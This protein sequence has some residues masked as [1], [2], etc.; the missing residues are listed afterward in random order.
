MIV[1]IRFIMYIY[2]YI[3]LYCSLNY[4]IHTYIYT[5]PV[6]DL[7]QSNWVAMP[8]LR[9]APMSMRKKE[10]YIYIWY[11]QH[12]KRATSNFVLIL[13]ICELGVPD[14]CSQNV[15]KQMISLLWGMVSIRRISGL[16]WGQWGIVSSLLV[17]QIK[18]ATV[19][20]RISHYQL[21]LPRVN[22]DVFPS[23]PFSAT[24]SIVVFHRLP[25]FSQ[26][27]WKISWIHPMTYWLVNR[28]IPIL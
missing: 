17:I 12:T 20:G 3:S 25:I 11:I 19:C 26:E 16:L 4:D 9:T 13:E 10:E 2:K 14:V 1:I 28:W 15:V 7:S 22:V 24:F 23:F 18:M 21:A 5:H 27:P 8:Q 6:G